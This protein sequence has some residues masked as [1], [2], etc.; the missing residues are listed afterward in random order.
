MEITTTPTSFE[1]SIPTSESFQDENGEF[2]IKNYTETAFV[3]TKVVTG[4]HEVPNT[5][6]EEHGIHKEHV[7][8]LAEEFE[9]WV[10]TAPPPE[11]R[12]IRIE[13]QQVPSM[14]V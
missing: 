3:I 7:M 14:K 10:K 12:L 8:R 1:G 5:F 2:D 6:F 4:E 13:I 11:E 9:E